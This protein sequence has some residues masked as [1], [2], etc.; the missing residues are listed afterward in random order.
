[1]H[2]VQKASFLSTNVEKRMKAE[3]GSCWMRKM[4][5]HGKTRKMTFQ[6]CKHA[7]MYC[8]EITVKPCEGDDLRFVP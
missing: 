7:K 5:I 6:T 8:S 3:I 1:M 2:N 4:W